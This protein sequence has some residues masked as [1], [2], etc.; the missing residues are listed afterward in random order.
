MTA[1]SRFILDNSPCAPCPAGK[2]T[3]ALGASACQSCAP[4]AYQPQIN[5]TACHLCPLD[6]YA[7]GSGYTACL[8]CPAD[9]PTTVIAGTASVLGCFFA[10]IDVDRVWISGIML[11]V[12][13]TWLLRPD[14]YAGVG[15]IVALFKLVPRSTI[16]RQLVWAY[17]SSLESSVRVAARP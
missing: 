11:N 14:M 13:V 5:A 17:T 16:S 1:T 15:D 4:G 12:A 3:M 6:S 10:S 8:R 7:D 9:S 2:Y